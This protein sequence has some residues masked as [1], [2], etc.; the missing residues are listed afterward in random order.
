MISIETE[1]LI[2]LTEATRHLP[3][4]NG[5]PIHYST[6]FRWAQR[7]VRGRKLETVLVGGTRFTSLEA[8]GRFLNA[9]NTPSNN[10]AQNRIRDAERFLDDH[11]IG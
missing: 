10:R 3:K 2:S 11:G 6:L 4:R 1:R 9:A 7:G 5:K 8:L